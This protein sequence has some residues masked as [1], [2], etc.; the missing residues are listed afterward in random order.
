MPKDAKVYSFSSMGT[1]W[2]VTLFG[3]DDATVQTTGAAIE[4]AA[5]S[6]DQLYSR[7]KDTSLVSTIAESPGL[8]TVPADLVHMLRLY[9]DFY[10]A[11]NQRFTPCV[12]R[13]LESVGYDQSY[14]GTALPTLA[15]VPDFSSTIRILD[16]TRI[17]VEHPVL[18]DVGA[19]GKGY[20]ID[21]AA[22]IL[23][24]HH[25]DAYLINGG[26]DI[27]YRHTE[28]LT[29]GL[30]HPALNSEIMGTIALTRGA[31]CG[32]A[33]NRR[34]WGKYHHIINPVLKESPTDIVG[35]WAVAPT[36][37]IADA[38][39]TFL[40]LAPPE[41]LPSEY[42]VPWLLMRSDGSAEYG[43]EFLVNFF[44]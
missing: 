3:C 12:G 9:Q 25:I 16:T 28:A 7:F 2:E 15:D 22:R 17:Q 32:S 19:I 44:S 35:S 24:K 18:L 36:A 13:L 11:S 31:L 40:F 39:A 4:D 38:V 8:Y 10:L 30:E 23:E 43:N 20:F 34:T 37:A 1:T 29:V 6:F 42:Q 14:R 5:R 21:L 41:K 26:G 33:G 27:R